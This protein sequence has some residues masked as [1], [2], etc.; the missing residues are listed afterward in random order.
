MQGTKK[1]IKYLKDYITIPNKIFYYP[2]QNLAYF[3]K[4]KKAHIV[5]T[6]SWG[7]SMWGGKEAVKIPETQN[8]KLIHL[9]GAGLDAIDFSQLPD[10]CKVCNVYEHEIPMAEYCIGNILY[11]EMELLRKVIKFKSLDWSD[12]M[13]FDGSTHSELYNK[14]LA[15]IGYG[16]IGK[17]IA[18]RIKPFG[19]E[20]TSYTRVKQKKDRYLT[21]V[22]LSSQLKKNI[23]KFDYI[24]IACPLTNKTENLINKDIIK[25]M[26]KTAVIINVAR[27]GIVNEKDL[28]YALK[29]KQIAGAIIDTWFKYPNS[30]IQNRFEPSSYRFDKLP[31]IIMTPH[32]SAWSE[33]MIKRRSQIISDNINRLRS[34]KKLI[35]E[36][37]Y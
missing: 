14:S 30:K 34:N 29:R 36:I 37:K 22:Y 27:G 26:K 6:M 1:I 19:V 11:W 21:N 32:I 4:I 8:L 18:K 23:H 35:N 17:E 12:C 33:G 2:K 7:K 20:V 5:I 9:P 10:K 28:Y 24:I 15:I 25:K 13:I 16:K 31:N 3:K